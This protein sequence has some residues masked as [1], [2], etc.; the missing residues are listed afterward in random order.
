VG[1]LKV[2]TSTTHFFRNNF[3]NTINK[4][5]GE[6]YHP[7]RIYDVGHLQK[8]S[9]KGVM[10]NVAKVIS[11]FLLAAS[12]DLLTQSALVGRRNDGWP[13]SK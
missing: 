11:M 10:V 1:I 4:G 13:G 5:K 9:R 6:S 3:D 8:G 7:A 12:D 2:Q